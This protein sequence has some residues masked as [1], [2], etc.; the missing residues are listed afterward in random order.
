MLSQQLR[1]RGNLKTNQSA[2]RLTEIGPRMTFELIKIEEGLCD[3]EVLYHAYISKTSKELAE[4]HRR[5]VEK[6]QLK[7]ERKRQQEENIKRKQEKT[8]KTNSSKHNNENIS[9][10]HNDIDE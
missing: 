1:S 5:N 4:L 8:I 3:G 9:S 2:I 7:Q 10:D 6:K